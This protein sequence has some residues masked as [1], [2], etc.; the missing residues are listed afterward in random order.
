MN[1]DRYLRSFH[2]I[3]LLTGRQ[4]GL[5]LTEIKQA[6]DLPASSVHNM[7]QTMVAA[8]VLAVSSD[9]KYRVGPRVIGVSVAAVNAID[10]RNH[11]RRHLAAL[12]RRC[13]HD[14]Y[15]GLRMGRR[16][17][18]AD[19]CPGSRAVSLNVQLGVPLHLHSTATGKLFAALDPDLEAS[20]LG[21]PLPRL[22]DHTIT[23]AGQ[24]AACFARIRADGH[25]SSRE[26]TIAGILGYAVPVRRPDGRI[27]A[28]VH[29]SALGQG[30][31]AIDEAAAID[32]AR[33]CAVDIEH[34]L[35]LDASAPGRQANPHA[36]GRA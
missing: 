14:I 23:D 21:G 16:V 13:G 20:V 30:A 36:P 17:F 15:L 7:L 4:D 29:V 5:R 22:T 24:L 10:V 8:D 3:S 32:A 1:P 18:Y 6:L 9:L 19:R 12:A 34:D 33:R 35:A 2:V 26:E 25:A 11:A 31:K 28:S 27:A